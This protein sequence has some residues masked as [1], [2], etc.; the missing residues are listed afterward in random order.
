ML[1]AIVGDIIG[2]VYE[3]AKL[4]RT[5]FELFQEDSR[6]T[7]DTVLTVAVAD[8]LLNKGSYTEIIQDYGR[9]HYRR[10][11]GG[12]FRRWLAEDDP[13][14]YNSFGNG[15]AMRVTPVGWAFDNLQEVLDEAKRSAEVTHN[16]PEGIKGAQSTAAAVFMALHGKSK[17]EIKQYIQDTF[18]YDLERTV[19][20]IRTTY[21]FDVTCQG[22][23]PESIIAFLESEN[24][25]H[26]I[27]LAISL[28][29]DSDTQ[30]C[31][32][33][34]IAQAYYK[35]IP[36]QFVDEIEARLTPDLL[37]VV[38][39]FNAAYDITYKAI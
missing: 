1:G 8:C 35:E 34:G 4:K 20:E 24:L 3:R 26:C 30:A 18:G 9:R 10:G 12:M 27:R 22:S 5:D 16:H 2:S 33:G 13:Q 14:P 37:E 36:Q 17:E 25:E 23:V 38:H 7:D 31:I 32:A 11:Y 19:D 15:S 39:K 21:K 28:G 29:G 6:F